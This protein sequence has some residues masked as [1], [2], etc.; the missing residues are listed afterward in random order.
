MRTR[1]LF[2]VAS[3]M[4][5]ILFAIAL[6]AVSVLAM[7]PFFGTE[8]KGFAQTL[9]QGIEKVVS[10]ISFLQGME[11][12]LGEILFVMVTMFVPA[13][14]L[15]MASLILFSKPYKSQGKYAFAAIIAILGI[16]VFAVIFE[17]YAKKIFGDAAITWMIG[18]GA[19]VV[20]LLFL[21]VMSLVCKAPKATTETADTAE[22]AP[23]NET[24]QAP[25]Q[26][27]TVADNTARVE[28]VTPQVIEVRVVEPVQTHEPKANTAPETTATVE[29]SAPIA[30]DYVPNE[31]NTVTEIMENTY[32][33]RSEELSPENLKKIRKL[34]GLLDSKA[35]TE[36]EYIALVDAYLNNK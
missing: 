25:T 28:Q 21:L 30:T 34:R 31:H 35:I 18:I 4:L 6:F 7:L 20:L 32:G 36:Q 17:M 9:G 12:S 5:A 24:E 11:N 1:R 8:M 22:A 14:L 3:A 19:G 23:T 33:K 15:L 10:E 27:A 2:Q 29:K 13:L 16:L 26:A